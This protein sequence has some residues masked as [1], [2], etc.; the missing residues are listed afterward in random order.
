M[1]TLTSSWIV[2]VCISA[3]TS[4]QASLGSS[5][6]CVNFCICV[7]VHNVARCGSWKLQTLLAFDTIRYMNIQYGSFVLIGY[8]G[9]L[10]HLLGIHMVQMWYMMQSDMEVNVVYV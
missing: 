7:I 9:L 3:S 1:H 5:D 6:V 2:R 10:V 4:K 8:G